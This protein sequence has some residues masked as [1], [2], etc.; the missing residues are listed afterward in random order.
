MHDLAPKVRDLYDARTRD[1]RDGLLIVASDR[2]SAYDVV[3]PNG[4]P[5]KGVILTQI[6]NFWFDMI[7]RRLGDRIRH[8]VLT[9]DAMQLDGLSDAQRREL[10]RRLDSK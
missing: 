10:A 6:S 8:H 1:G 5:G 3:M 4:V 7:A 2:I 9:T